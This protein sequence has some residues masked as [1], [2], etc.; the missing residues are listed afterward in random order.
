MKKIKLVIALYIFT[1]ALF[2]S[3][4]VLI[5][6]FEDDFNTIRKLDQ[7]YWLNEEF[8]VAEIDETDKSQL[9][10]LDYKYKLLKVGN[11]EEL[12][13]VEGELEELEVLFTHN[14][15][16]IVSKSAIRKIK[17]PQNRRIQKL[18]PMVF[19]KE[20]RSFDRNQVFNSR[21]AI[22]DALALVSQDTLTVNLQH[23]ED[24]VT[25]YC[26]H[27]NRFEV[28]N[29]LTDKFTQYGITQFRESD[30]T[31]FNH[32]ESNV[33]AVIPGTVS[34]E[35]II[36]IGGHHDSIVNQ[37]DPMLGAPGSDDNGTGTLAALETARVILESGYQPR[38][39]MMFMTYE[40]EELGLHG[41]EDISN[42][43]Y[44]NDEDVI[45]MLNNDMVGTQP[46][47]SPW[48]LNLIAY[49]GFEY[50]KYMEE[51]LA[52]QYTTLESNPFPQMDSHYSDSWSFA[53]NGFPSIF[54]QEHTFSPYY[55]SL[56]DIIANMNL[57]YFTEMVKLSVASVIFADMY[58]VYVDNFTATDSGT[59]TD[60][61]LNWDS[62]D[63]GTT[64]RIG[65]GTYENSYSDYFD[66]TD[67]QYILSGLTP[68]QTYYVGISIMQDGEPGLYTEVNV[69]PMEVPRTPEQFEVSLSVDD[70]SL[71]W[72]EN[73]EIDFSHYNLYKSQEVQTEVDIITLTDNFYS[74]LGIE[75]GVIYNYYVTAVDIDGNES[76]PTEILRG[77]TISLSEG[78]LVID[79]TLSGNGSFMRPTREE[80]DEF[81]NSSFEGIPYQFIDT[82]DI[83]NIELV[84]LCRY[85]SVFWFCNSISAGNMLEDA[86]NVFEQY[87][88]LG[89]KI[90]LAGYKVA[91][92]LNEIMGY[93]YEIME[94]DILNQFG[95]T[96]VDY[97][98][99][100][101]LNGISYN[102]QDAAVSLV[103]DD[104]L[105]WT[106]FD[107]HLIMIESY[108]PVDATGSIVWE[109]NFAADTD[110]GQYS[111]TSVGRISQPT[112]IIS[113][114]LYYLDD[115]R[116][117]IAHLVETFGEDLVDNAE[118]H[119]YNQ[120][121]RLNNYPNPFNPVTNIRFFV[122]ENSKVKL[123]IYNI[124]GQ[125]VNT[126]LD[127][128]LNRGQHTVIWNGSDK[129]GNQ[130][131]S[132][133][134]FIKLQS[135]NAVKTV[136]T[137]LMK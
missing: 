75:D 86:D 124:R 57:P 13:L 22:D 49:S 24:F 136:K 121:L 33:I 130:C 80:C 43:M 99:T 118:V 59:G 28:V 15:S 132:G 79:D 6:R 18:Y 104:N 61:Q 10:S 50:L 87:L 95:I 64:Y 131:S 9:N 56:D 89:G 117:I 42:E 137:V 96:A 119:T 39:T 41:S 60:V 52:G 53:R 129:S 108:T 81:Y 32:P 106:S 54:N 7:V 31:V 38:Y 128:D 1:I 25:R 123:E 65:V 2:A 27:P 70:I 46:T 93:P 103:L 114:P 36:I 62:Y 133:I 73:S 113:V 8:V 125:N 4:L 115:S 16:N 107:S 14:N 77:A 135:G 11:S 17:S 5:T 20:V 48:M 134:Y 23:L 47:D 71:Q 26:L 127:D 84:D 51:M 90:M 120:P 101:A 85:S 94:G 126:L 58:M 82:E 111:G 100:A 12:F 19:P 76:E 34:P 40:A 37:G 83:E 102:Y 45:F 67:T 91:T 35:K 105:V 68:G 30:F 97:S 69:T 63:V 109:T 116:T 78:L 110:Q 92:Q 3:D 29:W 55:H 98:N 66:T 21:N 88:D 44:F 112:S 122:N 72:T 74:D